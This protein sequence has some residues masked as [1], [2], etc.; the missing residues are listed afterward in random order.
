MTEIDESARVV[1]A[2]GYLFVDGRPIY[3]LE[4]FSVQMLRERDEA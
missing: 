2:D 3:H 4:S 1:V